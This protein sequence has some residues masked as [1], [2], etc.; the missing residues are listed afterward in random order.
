ML[1]VGS[2]GLSH[3]LEGQRA[4]HV[5]KAF[6]TRF[7][8]SLTRDPEWAT[9]FSINELVRQAGTQGIEL[10]NWLAARAALTGTVAELH[11]SYHIPISNTASG[12]MLFENR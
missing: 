10:L 8:D 6:D 1:I 2:G 7:M 4:G 9:R 11:R 3:Q 5:N 12:V